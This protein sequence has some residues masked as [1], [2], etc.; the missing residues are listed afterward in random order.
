MFLLAPLLVGCSAGVPAQDVGATISARL[1]TTVAEA[2]ALRQQALADLEEAARHVE[3]AHKLEAEAA[4][5]EDEQAIAAAGGGSWRHAWQYAEAAGASCEASERVH[6]LAV[7][8]FQDL[9]RLRLI[10]DA[11]MAQ[12]PATIAVAAEVPPCSRSVVHKDFSRTYRADVV[13]PVRTWAAK[14]FQEEEHLL[15]GARQVP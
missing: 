1:E 6:K 14:R 5:S 15:E 10:P 2:E 8:T 4:L 13:E 3:I 12:Y 11:D 7:S 9:N